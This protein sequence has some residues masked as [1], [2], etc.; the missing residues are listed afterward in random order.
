[1]RVFIKTPFGLQRDD[2]TFIAYAVG[3]HDIPEMDANHWY[4]RHHIEEITPKKVT[5]KAKSVTEND[6]S[7]EGEPQP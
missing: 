6:S 4:A 2:G 3:E 7:E 1:M 5:K